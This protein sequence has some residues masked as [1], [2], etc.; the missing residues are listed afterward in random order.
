VPNH[1]VLGTR[2]PDARPNKTDFFLALDIA[3][4]GE[5]EAFQNK[6]RSLLDALTGSS[7]DF[8]VPGRHSRIRWEE[9]L[10]DGFEETPD[11]R[12]LLTLASA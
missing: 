5:P 8:H 2:W 1:E 3:A 7:P 4:F 10:R 11:L 12:D 6:M 9:A